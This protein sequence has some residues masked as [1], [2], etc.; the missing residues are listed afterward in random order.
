MI[1]TENELLRAANAGNKN[2]LEA[3]LEMY[4]PLAKSKAREYFLVNGDPDDLIQEGMIGL[5]KAVV[6]FN[7][8]FGRPFRSFANQCIERQ[9]QSAVKASLRLKHVPLNNSLSLDV[10][11]NNEGEVQQTLIDKLPGGKSGDPEAALISR[12]AAEIISEI[13]RE[14]LSKYE[15]LTLKLHVEGRPVSEIAALVGKSVKSVDNALQRIKR[16][17]GRKVFGGTGKAFRRYHGRQQK[18]GEGTRI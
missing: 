10:Q 4:K 5:Y 7:D 13:I 6:G 11:S 2:A 12:E 3:L 1:M 14:N 17:I 8:S 16:K 18:V 15:L 9:I